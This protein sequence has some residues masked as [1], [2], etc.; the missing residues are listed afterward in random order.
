MV[1]SCET[2]NKKVPVECF[3][4]RKHFFDFICEYQYFLSKTLFPTVIVLQHKMFRYYLLVLCCI[5][6]LF[7]SFILDKL[8]QKHNL[9]ISI[10]IKE[11]QINNIKYTTLLDKIDDET[12]DSST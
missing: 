11:R 2:V 8:E 4:N 12:Q 5:W 1:K 3:R 6:I 9:N 10:I 7:H